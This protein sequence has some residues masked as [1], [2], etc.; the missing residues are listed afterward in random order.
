MQERE[1]DAKYQIFVRLFSEKTQRLQDAK[2]QRKLKA[3]S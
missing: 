1:I 2:T 3:K